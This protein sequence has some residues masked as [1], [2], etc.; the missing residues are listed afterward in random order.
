LLVDGTTNKRLLGGRAKLQF[1][2]QRKL[3]DSYWLSPILLLSGQ[4]G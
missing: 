1:F 2:F 4:P 3:A